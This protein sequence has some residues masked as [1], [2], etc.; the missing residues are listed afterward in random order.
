MSPVDPCSYWNMKPY[1]IPIMLS[2]LV[3]GLPWTTRSAQFTQITNDPVV[4]D[5]GCSGF[6]SWGD[7]DNDGYADLFVD[8]YLLGIDTIYRNNGDGTFSALGDPPGLAGAS[9]FFAHWCDWDNDGKQDINIW[10]GTD[11]YIG[12]GD[13]QGD[14]N[15]RFLT[16]VGAGEPAHA[17]YDR[18][19]LI[20][21]YWTAGNF[22]LHNQGNR[23]FITL[24]A[25][26]LGPAGVNTHGGA[27]WGDFDDDGW[28]D[29]YV[30]SMVESRSYMFRNEGNGRFTAVTNLITDTSGPAIRGAWGDYDNDGRLDLCVVRITG[31]TTVYRN[32]GNGEFEHPD[33]V[34]TLTGPYNFAAWADYDNDGF[35]D[36]WVSGYTSGNKLFRNNGDSSFTQVTTEAV[37]NEPAPNGA[38]TYQVAWFD[39]NNDGALD[40]YLMNGDDLGA[41]WTANQLFRNNGNGNAWLTVRP[42]GTGS[43]RDG[44]GAKVRALA[45]YAD[46]ARWQRRDISG[47]G[48]GNGNH[49]YAHF[50]LGDANRVDVLRIEWPSGIVQELKDVAVNRILTVTEPV[51]L[52]PLGVGT[53]QIRC[54]VNQSFDVQSSTDLVSWTPAGTVTNATGNLIFEDVQVDQH[55]CRYYRVAETRPNMVW[56]PPG[57]FLMGSPEDEMERFEWEGPQTEV[58]L[59]QGF[60][61]GKYEVTQGEYLAVMGSNPSYFNGVQ[62]PGTLD[63]I[64]Y[65]IYL[66][67]PVD[68]VTWDAAVAY[69]A[70]L[71]A[72]ERASRRIPANSGYR[73]PTEAEWE[74]A[75]RAGTTTRFSHG[76]DPDYTEL[77]NY[78]WY[79]G[80]NNGWVT[81]PVGQ[82]LP[83]PWGLFDMHG[84]VF[85][86]CRDWFGDYLGGIAMDPQGPVTG[87]YHVVR[88]HYRAGCTDCNN[89]RYWRSAARGTIGVI[90]ES[91]GSI[92]SGGFRVVLAPG[93]PSTGEI[94]G[95]AGQE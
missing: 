28:P 61:M 35:L 4:T 83:N 43:N 49:R 42:I 70:A 82:K 81:H 53:F 48:L 51:R 5:L 41:I 14:F 66:S 65:G 94:Q 19:G 74:Y 89:S 57:T 67:R 22:L 1:I 37:T 3:V 30:P 55:E 80:D 93:Q 31:Q 46:E 25:P 29:L 6:G 15:A 17:D 87:S 2:A 40:L 76:D 73:L 62:N 39:Y 52:I 11:A 91:S 79:W 77:V 16:R 27:C 21:S 13:G 69:C 34:P 7:F 45:T 59:T 54:W 56:I 32:L 60:W 47:G 90:N 24:S 44:V 92:N 38:G 64:D 10:M 71:T 18:D 26:D 33:G 78:A 12:Y 20:D 50:G 88:G 75:C 72:S 84:N 9:E 23:E 85:E 86:W 63:E 68:S 95:G 58:T 36:L 8:F